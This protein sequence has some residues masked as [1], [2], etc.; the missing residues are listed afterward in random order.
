MGGTRLG[1][2]PKRF[3]HC[4]RA[5]EDGACK[6]PCDERRKTFGNSILRRSAEPVP[7]IEYRRG[8]AECLEVLA[9]NAY[10][11]HVQAYAEEALTLARELGS[12]DGES[13]ALRALAVAALR[14]GEHSK[15][16]NYLAQALQMAGWDILVCLELLYQAD[17][18]RALAWCAGERARFSST[19]DTR[20][21]ANVME[22]Y[23]LMLLMEGDAA[24]A[25]FMLEQAVHVC[26]QVGKRQPLDLR[27]I[28]QSLPL[29][30]S[31]PEIVGWIS[32][33]NNY[34]FCF[35]GLGLAELFLGNFTYAEARLKSAGVSAQQAGVIWLDAIAQMLQTHAKALGG[36]LAGSLLSEAHEHLDRFERIG[37]PLG[38]TCAMIQFAGLM[39]QTGDADRMR[40]A[41][42]LLGA[43]SACMPVKL[44]TKFYGSMYLLLWLRDVESSLVAPALAAAR[45]QLGDAEFEAAYAAGQRMSLDEAVALALNG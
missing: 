14:A 34:S 32:V 13:R 23:G 18:K 5:G 24:Q 7:P 30:I 29:D 45:A 37:E 33:V 39:S 31:T 21:A 11:D 36:G 10:D 27:R 26:E 17:P 8:L 44:V 41:S 6:R 20:F 15:A 22:A 9:N 3:D 19:T 42:Q 4:A 16:V 25:R 1:A 28:V 35:L 2:R 12:V 40:F 38:I 43:V